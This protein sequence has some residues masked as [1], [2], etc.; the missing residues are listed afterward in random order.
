MK[1]SIGPK[2][3]IEG[4]EANFNVELK[5]QVRKEIFSEKIDYKCKWLL[6][7]QFDY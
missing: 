3:N 6:M 5:A 2:G 7:N 1:F 4:S